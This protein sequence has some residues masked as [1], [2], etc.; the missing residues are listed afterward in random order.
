MINLSLT[1]LCQIQLG[2]FLDSGRTSGWIES[3]AESNKIF[4]F[5]HRA[6][7]E[8]SFQVFPKTAQTKSF[9]KAKRDF[10]N[11]LAKLRPKSP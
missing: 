4:A 8:K 6:S 10:E 3:E 5:R 7:L 1:E 9:N 2:K 11:N